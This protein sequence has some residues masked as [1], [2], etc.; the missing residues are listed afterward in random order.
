MKKALIIILMVLILAGSV[1]AIGRIFVVSLNYNKSGISENEKMIKFG[2]YPD[3]KIQP[4]D[5]YIAE[6]ISDTNEILYSF[7]FEVPLKIYLDSSDE[8]TKDISGGY[9]LLDNVDFALVMPYFDNAKEIR[10]YRPERN[11]KKL[12]LGIKVEEIR[13][14]KASRLIVAG[15]ILGAFVL[16]ILLLL[17]ARK[18]RKRR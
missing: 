8:I 4:E 9:I 5:G 2:Y 14:S 1:S 16:L 3:R 11:A 6:L 12:E 15:S 18:T 7:R 13:L 17:L 10:I